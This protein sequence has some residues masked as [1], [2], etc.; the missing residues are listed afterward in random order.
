MDKHGISD[1]TPCTCPFV[2]YKRA[3]PPYDECSGCDY[4]DRQK[5]YSREV[6]ASRKSEDASIN[7]IHARRLRINGCVVNLSAVQNVTRDRT[8]IVFISEGHRWQQRW[9]TQDDYNRDDDRVDPAALT[10]RHK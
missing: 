6:I 7:V 10:S 5:M 3:N 8:V 4:E 9:R 2:S 1:A